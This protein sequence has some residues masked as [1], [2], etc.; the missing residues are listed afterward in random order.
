MRFASRTVLVTGATGGIGRGIAAALAKAGARVIATDLSRPDLGDLAIA[1]DLAEATDI[2]RLASE[3]R[4]FGLPDIVIGA[5]ATSI[6]AAIADTRLADWQRLHAVNTLANVALLQEFGPAMQRARRGAFVFVSSIN[7]AFATPGQGAYAA[8]KAAL[9]SV[10]RTAALELSA[11][12]VRV[13]SVRPASVD[14][15]L[16]RAGLA[17]N[18]DPVSA[19]AANIQRHPLGRIGT[20]DDVVGLVL[21]L[22]SDE[23]AWITG[24]SWMIDGGASVTRR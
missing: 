8:T 10:V 3:V 19:L 21:F 6:H 5:A 1:A 16:L 4:E 9:D 23:A 24:Q 13:N 22:A 12:G 17:A 15:P 18:A 20:I 11:D 2:A 7:A 14:T